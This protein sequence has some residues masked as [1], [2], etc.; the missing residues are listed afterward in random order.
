MSWS[1]IIT[2]CSSLEIDI[3]CVGGTWDGQPVSG[4]IGTDDAAGR[5][6]APC[7]AEGHGEVHGHLLIT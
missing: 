2:G 5:G 4:A 3:H 6:R 1:R 7:D